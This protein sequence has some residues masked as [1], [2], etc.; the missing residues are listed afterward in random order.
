[1]SDAREVVSVRMTPAG[2]AKLEELKWTWRMP[3]SEIVREAL[4]FAL[5][6]PDEFRAYIEVRANLEEN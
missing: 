1:M 5:A 6:Q 2:I 3:R 4:A